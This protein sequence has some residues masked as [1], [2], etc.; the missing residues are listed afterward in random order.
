MKQSKHQQ[1]NTSS[2]SKMI[3]SARRTLSS[4]LQERLLEKFS[5]QYHAL[6]KITFVD[7]QHKFDFRTTL[8]LYIY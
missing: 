4:V 7:N 2:V 6:M 8:A 3:I 1:R 5:R